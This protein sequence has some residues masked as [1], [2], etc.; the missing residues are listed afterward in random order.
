MARQVPPGTF[1]KDSVGQRIEDPLVCPP[2]H[3]GG[4]LPARCRLEVDRPRLLSRRRHRDRQQFLFRYRHLCPRGDRQRP[5]PAQDPGILAD[6]QGRSDFNLHP[7]PPDV[8][9]VANPGFPYRSDNEYPAVFWIIN[10][11]N[12]FQGDMA[13]GAGACG[14]VLLVRAARQQRHARCADRGEQQQRPYEMGRR[15]RRIQ[16]CR[17]AAKRCLRRHQRD[18]IL[19]QELGDLDDD[20]ATDDG[21]RAELR[22][23]H[24]RRRKGSGHAEDAVRP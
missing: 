10:G 6:N 17:D 3:P 19:L 23:V 18:R 15:H 7:K 16:L 13:A 8:A 24:R 2:R 1:V 12:N 14:V 22:R 5:E 4:H 20:V 11:W 9:D 21:R